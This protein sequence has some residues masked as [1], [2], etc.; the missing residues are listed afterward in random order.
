DILSHTCPNPEIR[1]WDYYSGAF[2]T[3]YLMFRIRCSLWYE[4]KYPCAEPH[5]IVRVRYR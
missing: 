2:I 5:Y 3:T 4:F 1:L